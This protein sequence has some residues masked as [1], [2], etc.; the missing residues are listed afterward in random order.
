[1]SKLEQA[2]DDRIAFLHEL[3]EVEQ[4]LFEFDK[5]EPDDR[6]RLLAKILWDKADERGIRKGLL[7]AVEIIE[8][9]EHQ[10][11]DAECRITTGTEV[12]AIL[13]TKQKALQTVRIA[14]ERAAEK[15]KA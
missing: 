5:E 4:G 7:Q 11:I 6:I 12:S 3:S 9:Q 10:L 13:R 1:M 15:E 14:I 2:R 8:R